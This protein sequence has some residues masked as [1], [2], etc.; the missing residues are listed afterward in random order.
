MTSNLGTEYVHKSGSLGFVPPNST[1]EDREAAE[2]ISKA[3][4]STF[5]PEFLN[6]IDEII[7]FSPLS[8]EDMVKIVDLQMK[9]VFERFSEKGVSVEL[10]PKARASGSLSRVTTPLL[11]LAR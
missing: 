4:K 7:T 3:L 2:K 9:E 5:R 1:T 6:R 10:T 11:A 8:L